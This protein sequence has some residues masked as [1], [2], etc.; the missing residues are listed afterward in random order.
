[1]WDYSTIQNVGL[2]QDNPV[3]E[4]KLQEVTFLISCSDIERKSTFKTEDF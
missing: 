4:H 1:M 3:K 2:D